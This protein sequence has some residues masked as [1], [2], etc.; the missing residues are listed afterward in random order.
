MKLTEIDFRSVLTIGSEYVRNGS[1]VI[2]VW[3]HVGQT[4]VDLIYPCSRSTIML[5]LRVRCRSQLSA[6]ASLST[7]PYPSTAS[8]YGFVVT[9]LRSS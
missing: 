9:E 2:D 4:R 5:R 6:A 3:F 8:R 7:L 1:K